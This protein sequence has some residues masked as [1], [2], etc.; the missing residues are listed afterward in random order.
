MSAIGWIS[1]QPAGERSSVASVAEQRPEY[2]LMSSTDTH[3][4]RIDIL[5]DHV[6][7][8]YLERIR[9]EAS[10]SGGGESVSSDDVD[11]VDALSAYG[12]ETLDDVD[13]MEAEIDALQEKLNTVGVVLP[14]RRCD[15]VRETITALQAATD[16]HSTYRSN[17]AEALAARIEVAG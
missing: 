14:E 12:P 9:T 8:A 15:E 11:M 7:D 13:E 2:E 1:V 16:A 3:E 10:A 4:R 5:E 6:T 17:T